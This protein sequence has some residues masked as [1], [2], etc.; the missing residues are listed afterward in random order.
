M[1]VRNRG[2]HRLAHR[3]VV[4][5]GETST[6]VVS[7]MLHAERLDSTSH[8]V[9]IGGDLAQ[10]GCEGF[11]SELRSPADEFLLQKPVGPRRFQ[12]GQLRVPSY[13][14]VDLPARLDGPGQG[15][16]GG[17]EVL[18][19]GGPVRVE[20]FEVIG[21]FDRPK[22]GETPHGGCLPGPRF[23]QQPIEPSLLLEAGRELHSRPGQ[24]REDA[25]RFFELLGRDDVE[26]GE[27]ISD[28]LRPALGELGTLVGQLHDLLVEAHVEQG[29]E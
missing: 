12:T 14:L 13:R 8:L 1:S 7:R 9:A 18:G 22:P 29:T 11:E 27:A 23:V 6:Q 25:R 20:G 26:L 16:L 4:T 15:R 24:F 2:H 21:H 5:D 19:G 10:S 28:R 17:F 3:T